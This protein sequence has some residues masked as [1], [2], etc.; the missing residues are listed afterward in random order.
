MALIRHIPGLIRQF[1]LL[2]LGQPR[3]QMRFE[4]RAP[5]LICS[6][7]IECAPP[8]PPQTGWWSHAFMLGQSEELLMRHEVPASLM[9]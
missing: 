5:Q 9:Y 2:R 8:P 1:P 7:L 3:S 4:L 6:P